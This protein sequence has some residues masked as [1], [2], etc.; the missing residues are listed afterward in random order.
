MAYF[1]H[2]VH[3]R[4]IITSCALSLVTF[5]YSIIISVSSYLFVRC[6]YETL[7]MSDSN[8]IICFEALSSSPVG[9][10]VPCGHCFHQQCFRQW[11]ASSAR[12]SGSR[13]ATC[14]MCNTKAKVFANLFLDLKANE[15]EDDDDDD[16]LS[17]DSSVETEDKVNSDALDGDA[18]QES[19]NDDAPQEREEREESQ[20]EETDRPDVIEIDIDDHSVVEILSNPPSSPR[21]PP[22]RSTRRKETR[23]RHGDPSRIRRK[24]KRLKKKNKLLDSQRKEFVERER[25]LLEDFSKTRE[26]LEEIERQ[27][28]AQEEEVKAA[29]RELEGY[30]VRVARLARERDTAF[31]QLSAMHERASKAEANFNEIKQRCRRDV[32]NAQAAAMQEVKSMVEQQPILVQENHNLKELMFKKEQQIKILDQKI[33]SLKACVQDKVDKEVREFRISGKKQAKSIAKAYQAAQ[34]ERLREE[35]ESRARKAPAAAASRP[36]RTYSSQATRM[37]VAGLKVASRQSSVMDILGSAPSRN[38]DNVSTSQERRRLKVERQESMESVGSAVHGGMSLNVSSSA[39]RRKIDPLPLGKG[40]MSR[41]KKVTRK[42]TN[43]LD[44]FGQN[45]RR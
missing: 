18:S 16:S 38:H 7:V 29:Q 36:A 26:R 21:P 41:E 3:R 11:E 20:N 17:S 44:F 45:R 40:F 4:H 1:V 5:A 25:K 2:V 28:E 30:R 43:M 33:E 39:K 24:A 35:E 32:E 19:N 34:D 22:K 8:C 31:Q 12:G 23:D 37:S 9:A 27:Q 14:P 42:D 10:V 15:E 6:T 13:Q